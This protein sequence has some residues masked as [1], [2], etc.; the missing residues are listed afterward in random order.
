MES[1]LALIFGTFPDYFCLYGYHKPFRVSRKKPKRLG[2]DQVLGKSQM[3]QIL[4]QGGFARH[5]DHG[6]R[7]LN[8][9]VE[10]CDVESRSLYKIQVVFHGFRLQKIHVQIRKKV[11]IWGN[12]AMVACREGK[13]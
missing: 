8:I 4:V 11:F 6:R 12:L 7:E 2:C 13:R 10:V 3:R 1:K 9:E 5:T